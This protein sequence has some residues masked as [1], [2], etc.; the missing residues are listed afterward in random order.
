MKKRQVTIIGGGPSGL[1]AAEILA[2]EGFGVTIYDRKA[3]VGRKFLMAGRGGL[4]LTHSEPISAF[5]RKYN[6]S[7]QDF[8]N[9]LLDSFNPDRLREWCHSLGE[10]TF[11]GSSGRVFPKS[12]KASPLL[13][14][15]LKKLDKLGVSFQLQRNWM[16]WN[17]TNQLVFNDSN[18]AEEFIDSDYTLLALGGA[19]W[20][21]LG[22]D[23]SWVDI[24]EKKNI[25]IAEL[26]PAN[27]GFTVN[28]S[29][30][31]Q[32]KF[33]GVPL[34]NISVS[35]GDKTVKGEIMISSKGIE[36]G[37][38]YA[39]SSCLRD[40]LENA[41]SVILNIDL[42]PSISRQNIISKLE[43]NPRRKQSM[44]TY[45]QKTLGLKPLEISLLREANS[46]L[47]DLSNEHLATLLKSI[48][49]EANST[50]PIE[51]AISCAG[52][53]Q[54][55]NLDR[56]MMLKNIPGVFAA[57]EMLDW[58]APTGGYL[59]QACFATGVAAARGILNHA[60][61]D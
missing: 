45:L 10:D 50:F 2:C 44:T 38:I 60:K 12:F 8:L 43:N 51:R 32:N 46:K 3:S 37:A 30:I 18:G 15:W 4:N 58:E 17:R 5:K 11:I 33:S 48:P 57:G 53:I 41:Q 56:N 21:N 7:A 42:R 24:L 31:F 52:G 26:R 55:E 54:L 1:I 25:S 35:I 23:A 16:G 36:G 28:W 6:E 19:S 13:R 47:G 49:I 59:L 14:S 9:P 34:K 39:L 27:C 40:T 20:P 61:S 29:E 22:S